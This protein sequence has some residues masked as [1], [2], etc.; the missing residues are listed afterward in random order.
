MSEKRVAAGLSSP[1]NTV[2]LTG[3]VPFEIVTLPEVKLAPKPGVV[4]VMIDFPPGRHLQPGRALTHRVHGGEA[5]LEFD[6]NGQIVNVQD[7][8]LPLLLAYTPREYPAPPERGEMSLDFSFWHT[9]G[10]P[11]VGQDVQWRVPVRWD[12]A[13]AT[14]V[15]LRFTLRG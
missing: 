2:G 6:R 15:D 14:L 11:M 4:R 13:G 7:T 8:I 5:G 1:E 12:A 3:L 10:T 9:D